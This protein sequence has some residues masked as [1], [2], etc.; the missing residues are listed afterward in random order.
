MQVLG[1]YRKNE[2]IYKSTIQKLQDNNQHL[3]DEILQLKEKKYFENQTN[4]IH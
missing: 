4:D 2:E 1:K 3:M